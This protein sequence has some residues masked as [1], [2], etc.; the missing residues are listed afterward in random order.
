MYVCFYV[1][2]KHIDQCFRC[3]IKLHAQVTFLYLNSVLCA[4]YSRSLSLRSLALHYAQSLC[5]CDSVSE[6]GHG[7]SLV[8]TARDVDEGEGSLLLNER[9]VKKIPI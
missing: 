2:Q 4:I 8:N 9:V 7:S 1:K 3:H 6:K 5:Q